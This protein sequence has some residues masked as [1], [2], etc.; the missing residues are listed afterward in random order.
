MSEVNRPMSG[1]EIAS[2]VQESYPDLIGG[3]TPWKTVGARLA[4]DIKGNPDSIFVRAGRGSYA[5][6]EWEDVPQFTVKPRKVN[7]LEENILVVPR[8][9]F[10]PFLPQDSGHYLRT[11]SLKTIMHHSVTMRR[12]DAEK[13]DKFV[14]LIPS[15]IIF[16]S[17]EVLSYKRTKKSPESRL[18]ETHS[19]IFGGHLQEEDN[20]TL[21]QEDPEIMTDFIF[22]E[23]YEE[24]TFSDPIRNHSFCGILYLQKTK[25][26]RQHAGI[27]FAIEIGDDTNVASGEPGYHSNLEFLNWDEIED[28]SVMQ[29]T[30]SNQCI[31]HLKQS[32][33]SHE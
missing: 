7:P 8:P 31:Q 27:V 1:K 24:L 30:W 15:F 23:L 20:P 18:H 13:T 2:L 5:L 3:M 19:I 11:V 6:K 29:D 22:R 33:Q 25:F 9:E 16:K 12:L 28:S 26:E 4:S 17:D 32:D 10:L 21:F 14:Q